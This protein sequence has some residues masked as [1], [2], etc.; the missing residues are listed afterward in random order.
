LNITPIEANSSLKC[1]R[2]AW[3][4]RKCQD[5]FQQFIQGHRD[6]CHSHRLSG[7]VLRQG[8]DGYDPAAGWNLPKWPG[9]RENAFDKSCAVPAGL[10]DIAGAKVRVR[11][12][13]GG[14]DTARV[15]EV[16][17]QNHFPKMRCNRRKSCFGLQ[18]PGCLGS[19]YGQVRFG[20][21]DAHPGGWAL[22]R[23]RR[24]SCVGWPLR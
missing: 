19:C 18:E 24:E 21:Y 22:Y 13:V 9:P 23:N 5:R 15:G 1:P 7:I 2:S 3:Q 10:R 6:A 14:G 16:L 12:G 8:G 20:R 17:M 11:A 4:V